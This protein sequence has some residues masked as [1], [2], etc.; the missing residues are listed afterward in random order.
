MIAGAEPLRK[1]LSLRTTLA[2]SRF[3]A[4]RSAGDR[5]DYACEESPVKGFYH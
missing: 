1:L 5:R 4:S 2:I 3:C